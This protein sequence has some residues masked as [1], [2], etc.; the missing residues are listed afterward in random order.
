M[1]NTPEE[2]QTEYTVTSPINGSPHCYVEEADGHTSYFCLG[3]GYMSSD[4][5][6]PGSD[7]ARQYLASSPQLVRD[8]KYYD[9]V[10]DLYWLPCT[11]SVEAGIIFPDTTKEGEIEWVFAKFVPIESE[12]QEKYEGFDVRLDMENATRVPRDRFIEV[13]NALFEASGL[14]PTIKIT[15]TTESE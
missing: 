12:L 4:V 15:E 13:Y 3:T 1:S 7:E 9:K 8:L 11:I 14:E 10:R 5:L 6:V 2:T